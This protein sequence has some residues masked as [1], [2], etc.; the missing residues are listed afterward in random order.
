MWPYS[1]LPGFTI[2]FC[3][4]TQFIFH[5]HFYAKSISNHV[6]LLL[7]TFP[8]HLTACGRRSRI[9]KVA[10][11]LSDGNLAATLSTTPCFECGTSVTAECLFC[12]FSALSTSLFWKVLLKTS[13]P[14]DT[15]GL[16]RVP[17]LCTPVACPVTVHVTLPV[18]L[19]MWQS[20]EFL[21]SRGPCFSIVS[22]S[23]IQK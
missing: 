21:E 20:G 11:Q 16:G 5:H 15:T 3:S 23:L 7:K 18:S 13:L 19:Y 2:S 6:T 12:F 17:H 9:I 8:V 1:C 4:C 22:S 14:S 10:F